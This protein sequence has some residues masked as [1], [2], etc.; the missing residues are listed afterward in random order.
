MSILS[1]SYKKGYTL[2][3]VVVCMLL[4]GIV[5]GSAIGSSLISEQNIV[6]AGNH[7]KAMNLIR[8][9]MEW[10]KRQDTATIEGWIGTPIV[11]NNVDNAVG[12]DELIN[13]TLTTTVTKDIDENL[14]VTIMLNWEKRRLGGSSVK[15]D[16]ANPDERLITLITPD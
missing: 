9:K 15:G 13:D 16:A 2:M 11:E 4:L 10:V 3:E 6:K 14:I 12:S 1:S 5:L 7:I 8:A